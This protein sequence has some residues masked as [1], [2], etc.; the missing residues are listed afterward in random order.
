VIDGLLTIPPNVSTVFAPNNAAF[1]DISSAVSN[2]TSEEAA[3]ILQYHVINGT[4]AYS[5]TLANGNVPT[6]DGGSVV[7]TIIEGEVFVNCARVITADILLANGVL[8]V[9]DSVLSTT[10]DCVANGTSSDDE[11]ANAYPGA[12]SGSDVPFTS[13]VPS[14]TSTN[15]ALTSTELAVASGFPENTGTIGGNAAGNPEASSTAG[16]AMQT[17][18][19][20]GAALFGGAV[21]LANM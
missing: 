16:A 4:V 3:A 14:A 2:L 15:A 9:L 20:G 13:G 19:I 1:Q 18:A 12:S 17:G 10:G 8:H 5:S 6:L 11:P 21:I 7:I